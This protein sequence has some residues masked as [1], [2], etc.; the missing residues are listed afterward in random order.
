MTSI[1]HAP[2][3]HAQ[4][5]VRAL[6]HYEFGRVRWGL[7]SAWYLGAIVVLALAMGQ[8]PR[9]TAIV[10]TS[11]FAVACGLR[12]RGGVYARGANAGLW[13]GA[14][15][16]VLPLLLRSAGHC[17][18]GNTCMSSCLLACVA[19]GLLAGVTIGLAAAREGEARWMFAALAT[20]LAG[21]AGVLGCAIIGVAGIAGMA[22]AMLAT[23][24]PITWSAGARLSV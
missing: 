12:W 24:L 5:R 16:L 2:I 19:G 18:V 11:L 13:A 15:P 23:S 22:L 21:L 10:G 20:L 9:V 4:L 8:S 17:C 6:R 3:D 1:D 7:R 14:A